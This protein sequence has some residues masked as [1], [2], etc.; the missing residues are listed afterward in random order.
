MSR[1]PVFTQ[2]YTYKVETPATLSKARFGVMLN[3]HLK[4]EDFNLS[5]I[6]NWS[7]LKCK[8]FNSGGISEFIL[9]FTPAAHFNLAYDEI[10]NCLKCGQQRWTGHYTCLDHISEDVDELKSQ[11][12]KKIAEDAD[13]LCEKISAHLD[14][15]PPAEIYATFTEKGIVYNCKGTLVR[16]PHQ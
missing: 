8:S 16:K 1:L 3:D 12:E 4:L 5:F 15:K 14:L 13:R 2:T 6:P 9:Q 10:S 7:G 11:V